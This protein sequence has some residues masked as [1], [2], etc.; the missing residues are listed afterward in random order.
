M[1][2]KEELTGW[3]LCYCDAIQEL[4]KNGL[5][6]DDDIAIKA[7]HKIKQYIELCNKQCCHNGYH[8][9]ITGISHTSNSNGVVY[10]EL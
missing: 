7:I 6:A 1:D 10:S 4:Q 8:Y 9:K 5:L 2:S 3:L